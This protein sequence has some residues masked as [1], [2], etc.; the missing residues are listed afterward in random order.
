MSEVP[1]PRDQIEEQRRLEQRIKELEGMRK[2]VMPGPNGESDCRVIGSNPEAAGYQRTP[3]LG[4]SMTAIPCKKLNQKAVIPTLAH[5][6]DA[7]FDLTA[8]S[9]TETDQYIEYGTG[10][11]FAIPPGFGMFLFPR[12]SV[13]KKDLSLANCVGVIDATY[14]GEVKLR[15]RVTK[16][17]SR[18]ESRENDPVYRIGDRVAQA[19][20]LP[21]PSVTF[22]EVDDL[23]ETERGTGGFGSTGS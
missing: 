14:R 7:G 3:P 11:A 6:N 23:D 22:S 20:I 17:H 13:S 18:R 21:L 10:L 8:T 5:K 19:V 4:M 1:N 2:M 15:F 9:M 16:D 12:S